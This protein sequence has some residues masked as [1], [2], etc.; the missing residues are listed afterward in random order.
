MGGTAGFSGLGCGAAVVDVFFGTE[1][2]AGAVKFVCEAGEVAGLPTF[3]FGASVPP[4]ATVFARGV[5]AV[6]VLVPAAGNFAGAVVGLKALGW[7]P[8]ETA[9][10]LACPPAELPGVPA[11][12]L[13]FGFG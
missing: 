1:A 5:L 11:S 7:A 12:G 4:G 13:A 8:A 6:G 3:V 10:V 2:V 9:G